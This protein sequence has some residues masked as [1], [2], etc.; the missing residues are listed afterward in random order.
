M[1]Y[2]CSVCAWVFDEESEGLG[3]ADLPDDWTCPICTADRSFFEKEGGAGAAAPPT[4]PTH[5]DATTEAGDLASYLASWRRESH[6]IEEDLATIQEMAITGRTVLDPM[7]TTKPVPSWDEILICGAQLATLPLNADEPVSTATVIGPKAATPL[8]IDTP[9]YVSHMSFGALSREVKIALARGSAAVGTAMCSGE[10]G[11]LPE[12]LAAAHRYIFEVIP[13][14]YSLTDHNLRAVDAVEIK[15]GQS[16]KPGLGGHLPGDKVTAEIAAIRG[17]P[18]GVDITSPSRFPDIRDADELR[19]K[20]DWLRQATGGKPVGVKL[21]AGR[22]EADL[23]VALA[24][25]PDFVTIDGRPGATGAAPKVVKDAAAIPTI[26]ALARARRF[27]D[28]HGADGVSLVVT[29]GLRTSSDVAKALAMG[30]DAVALASAALMAAGCQHY[31][32]CHTGRCPVGVATQDPE[33]RA[34]LDV[35]RSARRVAN[36]LGALTRELGDF[37]RLTGR[38]DVHSLSPSDLRT[39]S[40]EI[41]RY[42]PIA[43]VGEPEATS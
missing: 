42:T 38:D 2:V 15:I 13:N 11:I 39:T 8:V 19:A 35:E 28:D 25:G 16:A 34:R 30:A 40:P 32:I 9:V 12:S 43:H 10:G 31:R 5:G 14:R 33:L 27:L 1:R 37:A 36:Y 23:A 24:A 7:R 41:A 29:G 4:A 17:F 26:Y 20:I 22:I 6:P 18:P 21:A 3:W